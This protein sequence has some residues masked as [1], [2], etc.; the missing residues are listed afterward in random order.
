[1]RSSRAFLPLVLSAAL[2]LGGCS[3][4]TGQPRAA[5]ATP[6]SKAASADPADPADPDDDVVVDHVVAIS[7]DGLN[8]SAVTDL[9]P[10]ELPALYRLMAEGAATLDA[11][12]EQERTDTL[13]NHTGMLTGRPVRGAGGHGVD[14]NDDDGS[15]VADPAGE[16]VAGLFDV[17]H[18]HGG[19]TAF[20]SSKTKLDLL[21]RTWDAEHGAPDVTGADD[22]RDK[23]DRYVYDA[24]GS[25]TVDALLG[26]LRGTPDTVSFVH[27]AYPDVAG[28][29]S[30]FLSPAYLDGVRDADEQVGR[31]LDAVA[32][33]PDLQAHTA[34]VL[35]ADHGGRGASHT[36]PTKADDYTIPFLVWGP[37]VARGAD[38]YDLNT[39]VRRDPGAARTSYDGPQPIRNGELANLVLDL[40]DLPPVPGSTFDVR[41][42]LNVR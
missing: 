8:P 12:T 7:V 29:A 24:D 1:M 6:P 39:E 33:D 2:A 19:S 25:R 31:I 11:R 27:L 10:E 28:H 15:T 16:Y 5:T 23:V 42:D 26:R 22:G 21:D 32:S 18:D 40:L 20:Y 4:G 14:V 35:T 41:Q 36:D 30:G 3:E 9:G 13:P 34:V 17:V 38:L 37:G